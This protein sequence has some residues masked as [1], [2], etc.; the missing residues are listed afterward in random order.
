MLKYKL[1]NFIFSCGLIHILNVASVCA[2]VCGERTVVKGT[3]Q[4]EPSLIERARPIFNGFNVGHDTKIYPY[5]GLEEWFDP[6][7]ALKL[8][9]PAFWHKQDQMLHHFKVESHRDFSWKFRYVAN[10]ISFEN[11]TFSF[12]FKIKLDRDAYFYGI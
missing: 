8:G 2:V 3:N 9:H 5:A 11:T 6:Y 12:L 10:S 1:S 7:V 4:P